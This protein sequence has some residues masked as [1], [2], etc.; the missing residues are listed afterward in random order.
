M[1]FDNVRKAL[2]F[3]IDCNSSDQKELAYNGK[4]PTFGDLQDTNREAAYNI[5]DLLGM[6]DLYLDRK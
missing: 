5:A 6:S 3:L 1:E 2:E 4:L